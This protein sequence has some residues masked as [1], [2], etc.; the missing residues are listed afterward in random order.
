MSRIAIFG[1]T[2]DPV[3]LGH[4]ELVKRTREVIDLSK[5][6]FVPC[7]QSPFKGATVATSDQRFEMLKHSIEEQGI[8][9]WAV[10]S[11]FE[12]SRPGLSYSW[13]TAEAFAGNNPTDEWFWILGTDQWEQIEKWARPEKLQQLLHFIVITRDGNKVIPKQGWKHT[14]VSFSHPAS[15]TKIRTDFETYS[16]WL[17]AGVA[18]Y[19]QTHSIYS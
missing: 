7:H 9:E 18:E 5:V 4:I 17:S 12:I 8:S 13:E 15:A 16:Q 19:C 14:A 1:G 6:I 2:F 3:H 11:D 10:V